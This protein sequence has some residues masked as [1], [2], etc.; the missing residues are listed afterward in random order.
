[1][2]APIANP[3]KVVAIGLNYR[4]HAQEQGVPLPKA[5]LIFAKFPSS[6]TGPFDPITWDA[7]LTQQVDYEVEL[8]V[9]IGK[10]AGGSAKPMHWITCSATW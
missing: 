8:G 4:D 5:P 6:I 7:K 1:M 10:R 3:T 9:V 2:L